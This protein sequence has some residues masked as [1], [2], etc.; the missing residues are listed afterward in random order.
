V[1]QWCAESMQDTNNPHFRPKNRDFQIEHRKTSCIPRAG[2][3]S[4]QPSDLERVVAA[5]PDLPGAIRAGIL[6][7]VEAARVRSF[8]AHVVFPTEWTVQTAPTGG[9]NVGL[10]PTAGGLRHRGLDRGAPDLLSGKPLQSGGQV[11]G[12]SW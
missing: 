4:S 8:E 1:C 3:P 11:Q 2:I 9:G 6:A 5:W 7:M 12:Q 10:R